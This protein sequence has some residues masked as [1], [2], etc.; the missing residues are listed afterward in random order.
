M[1]HRVVAAATCGV[2]GDAPP[3]AD[4]GRGQTANEHDDSSMTR[5]QWAVALFTLAVGIVL[6]QVH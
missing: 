1:R 2:L 5:L 6:T 3:M 4:P